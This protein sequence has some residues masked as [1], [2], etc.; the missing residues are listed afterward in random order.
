MYREKFM[1]AIRNTHLLAPTIALVSD[2]DT[3]CVSNAIPQMLRITTER[4]TTHKPR[5]QA[6]LFSSHAHQKPN[7]QIH[8]DVP[9][10]GPFRR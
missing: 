4:N 7:R 9:H 6:A 1:L 2:S 5:I 3:L 10:H 8:P